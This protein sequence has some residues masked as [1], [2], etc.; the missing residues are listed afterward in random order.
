MTSH[1]FPLCVCVVMQS[2]LTI[3]NPLDCSLPAP[4]S[5]GFSR[6]E[7]WS[8]LELLLCVYNSILFFEIAASI[9]LVDVT[10]ILKNGCYS[11]VP[12]DR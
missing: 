12:F 2:C 7:Y 6:Q 8:E 5:M 1:K 11:L 10:D 4:L 3:C 9:I